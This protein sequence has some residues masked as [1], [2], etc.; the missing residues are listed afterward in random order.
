M[1]YGSKVGNGDTTVIRKCQALVPS[2]FALP[3][4]VP[5]TLSRSEFLFFFY[6]H[7]LDQSEQIGLACFPDL[8]DT[9]GKV[10]FSISR[11]MSKILKKPT[12]KFLSKVLLSSART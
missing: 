9:T 7:L 2:C 3:S 4:R 12:P 8:S 5:Q 6:D 10:C 11:K 1:D